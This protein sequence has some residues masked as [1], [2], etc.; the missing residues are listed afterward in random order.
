MRFVS[1]L[2]LLWLIVGAVAAGQPGM[3][4]TSPQITALGW[5]RSR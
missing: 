3:A 4:A 1:L 2:V 5:E